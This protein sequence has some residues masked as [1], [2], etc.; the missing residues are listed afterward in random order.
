MGKEKTPSLFPK[1]VLSP[2]GK[3][4]V[5]GK[6]GKTD[7]TAGACNT[8]KW[9]WVNPRA[10]TFCLC[11]FADEGIG[12]KAKD[13]FELSGSSARPISSRGSFCLAPFLCVCV[14]VSGV[15]EARVRAF[16]SL[17][18]GG[19]RGCRRRT[20][21]SGIWGVRGERRNR[22]ARVNVFGYLRKQCPA[23]CSVKT[24]F[25]GLTGEG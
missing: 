16:P 23:I 3:N 19:R 14:R 10:L 5:T 6:G 21:V 13:G 18:S 20:W 15:P 7:P 11:V 22:C 2:L 1:C 24:D 25:A 12:N 4:G 9:K 8:R 17:F